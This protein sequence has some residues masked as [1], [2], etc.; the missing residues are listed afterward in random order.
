MI[1]ITEQLGF[2]DIINSQ[3]AIDENIGLNLSAT[4]DAG[5]TCCCN[6]LTKI[7]KYVVRK[8][9]EKKDE[10]QPVIGD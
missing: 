7:T 4:A 1:G 2:S 6:R 10:D 9:K 5:S 3:P 8:M